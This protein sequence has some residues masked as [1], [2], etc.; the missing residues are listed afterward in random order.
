MRVKELSE[1]FK[2]LIQERDHLPYHQH[3]QDER[4]REINDYLVPRILK[5]ISELKGTE[6]FNEFVKNWRDQNNG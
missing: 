1:K 2:S 4:C 5:E 6:Q 3:E